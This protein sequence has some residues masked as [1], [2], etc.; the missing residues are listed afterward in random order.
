MQSYGSLVTFIVLWTILLFFN[1]Y[2]VYD[3]YTT[4]SSYYWFHVILAI[5]FLISLTSNIRDILKKNY[6][7][8]ESN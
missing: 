1:L 8:S 3:K 4:G 2:S 6:T 7:T 5:I